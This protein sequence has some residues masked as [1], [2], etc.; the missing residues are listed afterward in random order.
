MIRALVSTTLLT[1]CALSWA[2]GGSEAI[3]GVWETEGGG[4]VQIYRDGDV[5]NGRVVGSRDGEPRYDEN[6][7]DEDQRGRRLLGVIVLKGLEFAGDNEWEGGTI[8]S[9]DNGKTYDAQATLTEPDTLEA[10]GY[11]GV[12]LLGRT[13]TWQRI[14][15]DAPNLHQDLL[16]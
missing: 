3:E 4:Y 7:P 8:Y 2:A 13:Q 14:G 9:P 12:S 16:K 15:E 11:V 5:W 10:R 1:A 6:N